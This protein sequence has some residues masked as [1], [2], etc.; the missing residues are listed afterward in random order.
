MVKFY[1]G[2]FQFRNP[3][4]NNENVIIV[5]GRTKPAVG[6]GDGKVDL[7]FFQFRIRQSK[8][9]QI[10]RPTHLKIREEIAVIDDTH[11]VGFLITDTG[12][13]FVNLHSEFLDYFVLDLSPI[14][15]LLD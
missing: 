14:Y 15:F 4:L 1:S 5:G 8:I 12:L 2:M 3:G 9:S 13:N 6:L 7:L 10:F 11:L